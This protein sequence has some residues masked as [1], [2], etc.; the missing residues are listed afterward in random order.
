[1]FQTNVYLGQMALR[2]REVRN[3]MGRVRHGPSLGLKSPIRR[4]NRSSERKLEDMEDNALV[5]FLHSVKSEGGV[6]SE[7]A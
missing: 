3:V 4:P 6:S 7:N 5:D 2:L 1:V